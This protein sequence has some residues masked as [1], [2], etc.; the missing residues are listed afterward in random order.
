MKP[1]VKIV[2]VGCGKSNVVKEFSIAIFYKREPNFFHDYDLYVHSM[3]KSRKN[4][5][6]YYVTTTEVFSFVR[7]KN[8]QSATVLQLI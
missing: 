4:I 7:S 6:P 3:K 1:Q 5:Y 2:F 8:E